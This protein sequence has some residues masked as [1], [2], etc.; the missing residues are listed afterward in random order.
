MSTWLYQKHNFESMPET[1][2]KYF[3]TF[4]KLKNYMT[5]PSQFNWHDL[6]CPLHY[7]LSLQVAPSAS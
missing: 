2:M 7:H 5:W 3:I 6:K 1:G 4:L